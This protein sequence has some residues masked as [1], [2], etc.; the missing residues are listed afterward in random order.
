MQK[1]E[2]NEK[3]PSS[4]S[5]LCDVVEG[6]RTALFSIDYSSWKEL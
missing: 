3:K 1:L 2:N 6:E 4:L 5:F